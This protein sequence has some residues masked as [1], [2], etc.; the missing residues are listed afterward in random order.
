MKKLFLIFLIFTSLKSYSQVPP[1]RTQIRHGDTVYL[2][3]YTYTSVLDSQTTCTGIL[4]DTVCVTSY[5]QRITSTSKDSTQMN[6]LNYIPKG[7]TADYIETKHRVKLKT[8]SLADALIAANAALYATIATV[9]T[10]STIY[11]GADA[12]AN[13]S[14]VI[15]ASPVPASYTTGMVVMFKANTQNT[16]GCTINVNGLGVKTI[17]KRV[18][19]TP[20]TADIPS[21]AFCWL[22]YNGTNFVLLNPVVN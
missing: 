4:P 3:T 15:T 17:V 2:M 19:T 1:D 6:K 5:F 14:Y 7:D 18:S 16:T 12:G 13:D 21:Q 20:A 8:D 11:F 10:K 9:N 22:V